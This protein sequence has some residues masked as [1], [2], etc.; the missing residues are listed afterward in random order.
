LCVINSIIL[1][2]IIIVLFLYN[3]Y[4][5]SKFLRRPVIKKMHNKIIIIFCFGNIFIKYFFNL[6]CEL[7]II[8]SKEI[9]IKY[10]YSYNIYNKKMKDKLYIKLKMFSFSFHTFNDIQLNNYEYKNIW[11]IFAYF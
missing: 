10:E 9:W 11:Y 2:Y 7:K 8:Y 4:N 3:V 6:K 5:T 1:Y